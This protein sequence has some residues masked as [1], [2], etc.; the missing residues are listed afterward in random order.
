MESEGRLRQTDKYTWPVCVQP[1]LWKGNGAVRSLQSQGSASEWYSAFAFETEIS[2]SLL[3]ILW[4]RLM[5]ITWKFTVP[6]SH[7]TRVTNSFNYMEVF[8]MRLKTFSK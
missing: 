3:A 6:M 7:F 8:E 4:S 2:S 1:T 5:I